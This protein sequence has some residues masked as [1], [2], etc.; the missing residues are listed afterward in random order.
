MRIHPAVGFPL[1]RYVPEGGAEVCGYSLPAGTNI[2]T[3]APL[4]HMD[5]GVFGHDAR[6]FRPERWLEASPEQLGLMDRTFIAVRN[7]ASRG[8][9]AY[10][11]SSLAVWARFSNVHR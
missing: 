10:L 1:E 2:S 8:R 7:L 3:S 6:I 9:A 5:K 4:M 11:T